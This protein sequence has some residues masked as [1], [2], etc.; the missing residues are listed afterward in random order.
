PYFKVAFP[1]MA[2]TN[3]I[4]TSPLLQIPKMQNS[5]NRNGKSISGK[6]FLKCDNALPIAGSIKARGG[7]Y[8]VLL[9]AER[10]ALD[11][12]LINENSDYKIFHS[13]EFH[14]FFSHYNLGVGSTGNFGLSNGML[15]ST[16]ACQVTVSLSAYA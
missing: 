12:G 5:L 7:F 14:T 15:G 2:V 8:E 16:L 6:L 4:L 3:G 9:H 1:E 13:K 11:A 10:L